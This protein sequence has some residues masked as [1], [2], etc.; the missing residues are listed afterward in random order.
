MPA[1]LGRSRG[2]RHRWRGLLVSS[3]ALSKYRP[4]FGNGPSDHLDGRFLCQPMLSQ[5][6]VSEQ[7]KGPRAGP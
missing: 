3:H 6:L 4:C 1:V 7:Q 2:N 5:G